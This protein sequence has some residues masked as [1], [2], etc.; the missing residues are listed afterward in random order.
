V[1]E[2]SSRINGA[3][4]LALNVNHKN[5]NKFNKSEGSSYQKILDEL[6]ILYDNCPPTKPFSNKI[7]D[8]A[9]RRIEEVA[10]NVDGM[11]SVN[12]NNHC[13]L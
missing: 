2:K 9:E 5:L 13:S 11:V 6:S 1:G 7:T 10:N 8:S 3:K 4:S 12:P